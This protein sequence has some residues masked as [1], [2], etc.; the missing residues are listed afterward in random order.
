MADNAKKIQQLQI[1]IQK[2]EVRTAERFQNYG[3]SSVPLRESEAIILFP[4]GIRD[5]CI[6][7]AVDDRRYRPTDWLAGEVGVY[8]YQGDMVRLK[9][10][11]IVEVISGTKVDVT[12]PEVIVH[13][14]T[15]IRL[16]TPLVEVTQ[17]ITIAGDCTV[18]GTVSGGTVQQGAVVLGTH[19]HPGV[20]SGGANTGG[21][22]P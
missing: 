11:R 15:K 14:S 19:K 20:Q 1:S 2:D 21:A 18:T 7:I 13:A 3:F 5:R 22:I 12:A 17:D 6:A 16:E 10:G 9:N 8:H 4:S